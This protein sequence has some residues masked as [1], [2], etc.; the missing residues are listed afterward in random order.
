MITHL[1]M[2][3]V[4]LPNRISQKDSYNKDKQEGIREQMRGMMPSGKSGIWEKLCEIIIITFH[5][6]SL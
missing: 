2:V 3:T 1:M 4:T 6:S 5:C